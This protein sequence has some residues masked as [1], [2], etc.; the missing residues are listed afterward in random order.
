[1]ARANDIWDREVRNLSTVMIREKNIWLKGQRTITHI[2]YYDDARKTAFDVTVNRFDENFSLESRMDAARAAFRNGSWHITD[3]I[4]QRLD[5]T[6]GTS[7]VAFHDYRV[8]GADDSA[9]GLGFSPEELQQV[10]KKSEEMN[11]RELLA[12]IRK[13]ES[14]GYDATRYR[15]DLH[16]KAAFPFVCVIMSLMGTGIALRQKTR[17]SLAFAVVYGLSAS[18]LYWIFYSFCVS[19]GYGE[20][21]PPWFAAWAANMVFSCLGVYTL[22]SAE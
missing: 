5:G 17:E 20:M 19:L 1:M 4:E 6:E 14:E 22:L 10:A 21:L 15:V 8:V 3:I 11:A 2:R 7:R 16:T 9:S 12:Y 13:I 18:F